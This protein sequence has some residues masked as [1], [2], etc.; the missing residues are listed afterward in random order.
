MVCLRGD[1]GG[2]PLS[3]VAAAA[4]VAGTDAAAT[5]AA[6]SH[7]AADRNPGAADA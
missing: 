4:G 3:I 5:V 2:A 1:G 6:A 7:G